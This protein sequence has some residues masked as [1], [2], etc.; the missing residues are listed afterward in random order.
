MKK[1]LDWEPQINLDQGIKEYFEWL[2]NHEH[3]IPEWA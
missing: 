3:I 1:L 2:N